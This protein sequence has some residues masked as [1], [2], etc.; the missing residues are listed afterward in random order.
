M[1]KLVLIFIVLFSLQVNAS[2]V[3]D[4]FVEIREVIPD[5]VMDIR[6]YTEHNFVGARVDGYE[7]PKCYLTRDAARALAKVQADLKP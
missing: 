6:Y 4:D 3:P 7:A 1:K 5:A 2:E